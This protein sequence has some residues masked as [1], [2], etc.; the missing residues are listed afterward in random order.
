MQILGIQCELFF[1]I[2]FLLD[3]HFDCS[4]AA[5]EIRIWKNNGR[6]VKKYLMAFSGDP[7]LVSRAVMLLDRHRR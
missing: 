3:L 7:L 1:S 4:S 2:Y 5:V 6:N